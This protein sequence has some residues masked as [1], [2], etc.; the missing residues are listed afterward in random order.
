MRFAWLLLLVVGCFGRRKI[1]I[2]IHKQ[3]GLDGA[4]AL[5]STQV[6]GTGDTI[7]VHWKGKKY[8]FLGIPRFQGAIA[9]E[10]VEIV[11]DLNNIL[12]DH[13]SLVLKTHSTS[14][15]RLLGEL[16]PNPIVQFKKD[17]FYFVE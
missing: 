11:W 13:D 3:Q 5:E 4:W 10:R 15:I 7:V 2:P 6:Q 17:G 1:V 12:L 9:E 14:I 8:T 16:P